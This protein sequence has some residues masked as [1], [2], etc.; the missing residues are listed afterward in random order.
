[1][2]ILMLALLVP[3]VSRENYD[4]IVVPMTRVE[5]EKLLGKPDK[6]ISFR[7]NGELTVTLCWITEK[8][9][10][11]VDFKDSKFTGAKSFVSFRRKNVQDR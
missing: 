4:K 5:V 8:A 10:V 9:S 3:D 1:M 2:G 6:T 11:S 7:L